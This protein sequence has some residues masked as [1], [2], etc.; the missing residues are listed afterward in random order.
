ML[1]YH[2]DN[3]RSGLNSHE[4]VLTLSNVNQN[5]FGKIG[6][7]SADGKVDAEPLYIQNLAIAGG[8]HN[9]LYVA[10]EHD[11]V[12]AMDADKGTV[13]WQKS[14]LGPG[15]A[16]SDD[17]GCS[18]VSP[19]IGVTA[20]P[21]IDPKAGPNGTIYIVAMSKDGS[22]NYY[23]RFHALD[24]T[25]GT[26]RPNSP[27]LVNPHYPGTGSDSSGGQEFLDPSL[28]KER[29]GLLLLGGVVYT[30]W[31]SHCDHGSYTSWIVGYN[32]QTLA[33]SQVLNLEPNGYQASVWTSGAGP[34]ADSS[35]NIY[36]IT[37]NGLF[38][39]SLDSKGFPAQ[40]DY[41]NAFVKIA[42]TGGTLTVADYFTMY[43]SASESN[44]D[45]DFGSG[46]ALLLPDVTDASGHTYQLA[47]GAGKDRNIY[48]VDRNNMGKFNSTT[49]NIYQELPL[50]LGGTMGE[51]G[52]PAYFN[53]TVYYGAVGDVIRAFPITQAKLST[54]S[55]SVS[56][57]TFQY[58]G[59][60][61]SISANGTSNGIVWA[62]DNQYLA[63]LYAYDAS[64]LANELYDSNQA[65]GG[66][67]QFGA[68]NKFITPMIANGKVYAGTTNGVAVFGL[69]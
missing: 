66:R 3:T 60:T 55:G 54:T 61:P 46:G 5:T 19:E 4:T 28:Y 49:N 51:Y 64:D 57:H 18:Q 21:V 2:D 36:L 23:Q 35:G 50:E 68:G 56:L 31:S 52:M 1:T 32:E 24:L 67:D 45:E 26:E 14:M 15:E 11:T 65:S 41:G 30:F 63:V 25:T 38:D 39:S 33:Q 40:Q 9:V 37:G 58:P 22:G 59:T 44:V 53:N 7:Y 47:V 43:N 48:I 16:P 20:T 34:A 42:T 29:P 17:R 69:R 13:L 6:F 27:V 10:T 62:I 8:T 12:Y